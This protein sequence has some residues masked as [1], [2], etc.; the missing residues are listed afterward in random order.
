MTIAQPIV[1]KIVC[2]RIFGTI[3][4]TFPMGYWNI[5]TKYIRL[6]NLGKDEEMGIQYMG[7]WSLSLEYLAL[8]N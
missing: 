3:L 1:R 4:G 7:P 6:K 8:K 2:Y 5:K